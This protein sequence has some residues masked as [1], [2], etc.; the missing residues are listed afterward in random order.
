ML[1]QAVRK[2]DP[3]TPWAVAVV[4]PAAQFS[5]Q[6]PSGSSPSS[7]AVPAAIFQ[8]VSNQTSEISCAVVRAARS[9]LCQLLLRLVN[10][11]PMHYT[12]HLC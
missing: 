4:L 7:E 1:L 3:L 2:A 9:R 5:S 11:V 12:C 6:S 10:N 8:I